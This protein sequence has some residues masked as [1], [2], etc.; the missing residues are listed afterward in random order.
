MPDLIAQKA[1][2]A[3]QESHAWIRSRIR[4]DGSWD[5]PSDET[6]THAAVYLLGL[7]YLNAIDP[8]EEAE[9][10]RLLKNRQQPDGGW[11]G[12]PGE[13]STLDDTVLCYLAL[14]A[15]GLPAE[16]SQLATA[17]T[18]IEKLGGLTGAS[19]TTR[20]FLT[21]LGQMPRTAFPYFSP[22]LITSSWKLR[23]IWRSSGIFTIGTTAL[24]L[25]NDHHAVRPLPIERG[26][27]EF[28][29]HQMDWRITPEL[30]GCCPSNAANAMPGKLHL[31]TFE[32]F[33]IQAAWKFIDMASRAGRRID[34]LLGLKKANERALR[35]ILSL[36]GPDGSYGEM[37]LPTVMN[38][39][40]LDHAGGESCR[41]AVRKG[42]AA[43]R[44]WLV[45]SEEG[46]RQQLA[47]STTHTTSYAIRALLTNPDDSNRQAIEKGV[48]WLVQ[49]QTTPGGIF[50]DSPK[51]GQP[52]PGAWSFSPCGGLNCDVDQTVIVLQ[53]LLPLA[54]KI[55]DTF[56]RAI[57]WILSM[58]DR[59][60]GWAAYTR[61]CR[62]FPILSANLFS[63]KA[64][65]ILL[66]EVDITAR[67]L[68]VLGPLAGSNFDQDG[69][70]T[71]AVDAAIPFLRR[72]QR[73]DGS[74]FGRWVVNYAPAT[75]QVIDALIRCGVNL[76]DPT[77]QRAAAWLESAQNPDGGWGETKSSYRTGTF[78]S[79]PS[80]PLATAFALSGLISLHGPDRPSVLKGIAHLI[81]S[82]Q[83]PTWQDPGWN[84]VCIPGVSYMRYNLTPTALAA[85]T[86][87]TWLKAESEP[88]TT[89]RQFSKS[90]V[91]FSTGHKS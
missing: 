9:I 70:I 35:S 15:S 39:M 30:P 23:R 12:A 25:L 85:T 84:G 20:L 33:A 55:P 22:R 27:A 46:L 51:P 7:H 68:Q 26:L 71:Q 2:N 90:A 43:I 19:F 37:L 3:V 74:W 34:P 49:R 72:Q 4:P 38:L 36:Q 13:A 62:P 32:R 76:H 57:A 88:T 86:L 81:E 5:E 65:E 28:S 60:G 17:R 50:A 91:K 24:C 47:P 31:S 45:P 8:A 54:T 63:P 6:P 21:L 42:T 66:P 79:G 80:N 11:S 14:R 77:L 29:P 61:G 52:Q 67:V 53:S 40:A 75:G 89:D 18:L 83:G 82:R 87:A 73:P 41:E 44:G 78:E 64:N 69:R 58:R 56:D 59:S 16:A 10:V 48:D 1:R